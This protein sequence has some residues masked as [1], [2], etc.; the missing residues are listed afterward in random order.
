MQRKL[1]NK[2]LHQ[3]TKKQL[4]HAMHMTL[5]HTIFMTTIKNDTRTQ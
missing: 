2:S 3:K 4:T 1:T 5:M